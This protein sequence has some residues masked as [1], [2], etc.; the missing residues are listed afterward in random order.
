MSSS[1]IATKAKLSE[2]QSLLEAERRENTA[3]KTRQQKRI[4]ELESQNQGLNRQVAVNDDLITTLK[5]QLKGGA[6][7]P[8]GKKKSAARS[9]A[10]GINKGS[11]FSDD[12]KS[13][14]VD[15]LADDTICEKKQVH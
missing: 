11:E 5:H 8:P 4:A 10:N 14:N 2:T 1:N 6:S 7:N 15:A 3:K 12:G 9:K 13:N